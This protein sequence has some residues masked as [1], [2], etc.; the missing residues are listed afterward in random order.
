[1]I[2]QY[3]INNKYIETWCSIKDAANNLK[4]VN[5]NISACCKNKKY[6]YI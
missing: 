1:M 3:D 6:C 5:N 4:I 2:C